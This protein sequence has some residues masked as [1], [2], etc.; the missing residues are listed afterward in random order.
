MQSNFGLKGEGQLPVR[1]MRQH[2]FS[3]C[4]AHPVVLSR[5]SLVH[6]RA[7]LDMELRVARMTTE[8]KWRSGQGQGVQWSQNET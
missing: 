7:T 6:R 4:S 2:E 3:A 1:P 5:L 8:Y